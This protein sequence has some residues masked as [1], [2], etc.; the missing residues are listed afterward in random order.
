MKYANVFLGLGSNIADRKK[1]IEDAI[2]YIKQNRKI[3]I[4]QA[5]R[6]Y[7]SPPWG[8]KNQENFY[9]Q[10]IKIQT[11]LDP[12]E[13]LILVKSIEEK[14]LRQTL[15]KWG[16]RNIDID[17][18]LFSNIIIKGD[19]LNIPHRYLLKRCFWLVAL[20]EFDDTIKVQGESIVEILEREQ[21]RD[22]IRIVF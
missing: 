16:P 1:N 5:S 10:A 21:D 2:F 11:D 4:I 15:F 8:Y 22:S 19:F 12:Y 6:M 13:L 20:A 7:E 17:I 9:N 14:M 3:K 18:L